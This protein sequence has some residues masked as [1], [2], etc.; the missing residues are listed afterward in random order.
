MGRNVYEKYSGEWVWKYV[1]AEQ[2]SEQSSIAAELDIGRVEF[3]DPDDF[4]GDRLYMNA[5]DIRKLKKYLRKHY[6]TLEK[7]NRLNSGQ[8]ASGIE[9]GQEDREERQ[10]L[11]QNEYRDVHFL[12][13]V[14]R[15]IG[16][17]EKQKRRGQ[18]EFCFEGEY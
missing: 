7:W 18:R 15:Y 14:D 6:E 9:T 5:R 10:K 17:M 16:F 8:T 12:R 3:P 11:L 2:N 1:L 13:M 4:Y